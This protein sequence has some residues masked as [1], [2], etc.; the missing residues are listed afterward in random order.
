MLGKFDAFVH[1]GSGWSVN[2]V[3]VFSLNVNKFTLFPGGGGYSRLSL[4]IKSHLCILIGNS[5]DHKCFLRCIAAALCKKG[6]NVGQWC[7]EYEKVMKET[8]ELFLGFLTFPTTLKVIK[9]F[10]QKWPK[11]IYPHYLSSTLLQCNRVVVN[12]LLHSGH[13]YL[14]KNMSSK[15]NKH[16]CYVCPCYLSYFVH[17]DRY[18]THIYLSKKD[19]TQYVF[20]EGNEVG[21]FLFQHYG[22]C[23]LCHLHRLGNNDS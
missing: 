10:E 6:R 7:G 23:T 18:E 3:K 19:G 4:Q 16:K 13:F 20:S 8:K 1:Q 2:K 14:I 15:R 11:L 12:L 21:V 5:C 9:K 22:Q 17:K